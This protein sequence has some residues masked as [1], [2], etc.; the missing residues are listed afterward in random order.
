[1]HIP[2]ERCMSKRQYNIKM[3]FKETEWEDVSCIHLAPTAP[4]VGCCE[5]GTEPD[6]CS[7]KAGQV[8]EQMND[9]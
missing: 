6:A 3:D 9:Y 4:L 1:M 5:Q 7:V 8:L 2:L